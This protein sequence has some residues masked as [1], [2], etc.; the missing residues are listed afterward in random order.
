KTLTTGNGFIRDLPLEQVVQAEYRNSNHEKVCALED[1]LTIAK[2]CADLEIWID[3]KDYGLEEKYIE[4]IRKH[5]L[6]DRVWLISWTYQTILR[7]H[8]LAPEIKI[9][10]SYACTA[11]WAMIQPM[12]KKFAQRVGKQSRPLFKRRRKGRWADFYSLFLNVYP[13]NDFKNAIP[14][15]YALGYNHTSIIPGLPPSPILDAL[16]NANGAVGMF[17]SQATPQLIAEAHNLGLI[18]YIFCIDESGRLNTYLQK[19]KVDIVFT[20]NPEMVKSTPVIRHD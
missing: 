8:Q 14:A 4:L 2:Q 12:I 20:N 9:G 17:P 16:I 3:I 11:N 6:E 1:Y 15:N 5:S 18:V 10:L 13:L 19:S 7:I